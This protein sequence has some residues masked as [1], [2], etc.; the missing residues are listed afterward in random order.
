[1]EFVLDGGEGT[2]DK[3]GGVRHN[4]GA[5][6][7]DTVFGLEAEEPGEEFADGNGGLEIGESGGEGGGEI[8]GSMFMF[9]EL[10]MVSAEERFLIWD[11]HA[12]TGAVAE[13]MLTTVL[14]RSFR[15]WGDR[16]E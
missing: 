16:S 7:G 1:M 5:A 4:G 11:S 2:E 10:R 13:A 12:T 6:R 8:D 15:P 9:R 14:S 3:I